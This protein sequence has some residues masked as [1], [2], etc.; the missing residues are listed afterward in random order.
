MNKTLTV[1]I[2]SYNVERFLNQTLDSFICDEQTM[3]RLEVLVVDD[4]SKDRTA[5]IGQEYAD[6]YPNTFRVIS[7]ENGGHGSTINCGIENASGR[8]FKVVDGDDWV[9]TPD[10]VKL[11]AALENC[12]SEYV[13]TNFYE[14]YDDVNRQ[15]PITFSQFADGQT[16][17]FAEVGKELCIPMHAI[18]IQTAVLKDNHLR[19]D[20]HCFYVDVEYILFPVPFVK[21]ITFFNLYVY[22]YRLNLDTQSVSMAGFQKHWQDHARVALRLTDFYNEYATGGHAETAKLNYIAK[23]TAEMVFKQ[24]DIFA[25]FPDSDRENRKRFREFD[26]QIRQKN[27]K[28]YRQSG[29]MSRRL[30]LLRK[31]NFHFYTLIQRLGRRLNRNA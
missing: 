18:V 21:N 31:T 12:T 3:S 4:G 16:Y 26:E 14:Y 25:S 27:T 2:P 1:V 8:Y 6:R 23:R 10:F 9:N 30:Q 17:P 13:F 22:M 29:D 5:A 11:V 15:K 7:K 24:S 19:M 28:I 20:E